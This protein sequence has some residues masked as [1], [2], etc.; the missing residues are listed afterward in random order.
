M[1]DKENIRCRKSSDPSWDTY[2]EDTKISVK[3]KIIDFITNVVIWIV[4]FYFIVYIALSI[5][6][7]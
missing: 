5:L 3:D 2:E 7:S 4:V 1:K 6:K